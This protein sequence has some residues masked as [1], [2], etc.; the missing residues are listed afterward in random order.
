MAAF[1]FST[2]FMAKLLMPLGKD[3]FEITCEKGQ[4]SG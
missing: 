1:P 3:A 2:A 4:V